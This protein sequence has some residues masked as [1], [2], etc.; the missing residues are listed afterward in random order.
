[1][2]DSNL[3]PVAMASTISRARLEALASLSEGDYENFL[4]MG[5]LCIDA[6]AQATRAMINDVVARIDAGEDF[7]WKAEIDHLKDGLHKYCLAIV[8]E[9]ESLAPTDGDRYVNSAKSS[10]SPLVTRRSNAFPKASTKFPKT[11]TDSSNGSTI[12]STFLSEPKISS[13]LFF[14]PKTSLSSTMSDRSSEGHIVSKLAITGMGCLVFAILSLT[15]LFPV[16]HI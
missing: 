11:S 14:Y 5:K 15:D 13:P 4:T 12:P 16:A 3:D 9:A 7:D 6:H 1:M 10:F 2:Y 8:K